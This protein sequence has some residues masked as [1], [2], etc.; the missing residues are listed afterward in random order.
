MQDRKSFADRLAN[1]K[2]SRQKL[3][4]RLKRLADKPKK[5][6]SRERKEST[7]AASHIDA[8]PTTRPEP[9]SPWK[10]ARIK[11]GASGAFKE[12]ASDTPLQ[13]QPWA[14]TLA[15]IALEAGE[16][17]R[18]HLCFVW[19]A[20]FEPVALL[21]S[22]INIERHFAKD[23]LGM[24][25]LLYPGTHATRLPLNST[26]VSRK[27]LVDLYRSMLSTEGGYAHFKAATTSKAFESVLEALNTIEMWG[28]DALDPA[29]GA[30]TP[31]F[32]FDHGK[33]VWESESKAQ[34]EK[35]LRK[36]AKRSNRRDIKEQLSSEWSDAR[37]APGALFV[38]HSETSRKDWKEALAASVLSEFHRPELLI[39]NGT[40]RASQ[41]SFGAVQ[42][43]PEFLKYALE[44]GYRSCGAI[45]I[46]DD[47]KSFFSLRARLA[48]LRITFTTNVFAAEGE[49]AI[50]ATEALPDTWQPAQRTLAYCSASIVDR[51]ASQAALAFQRI[52]NESGSE[53]DASHA[54]A[55][56]ACLFVLRLSNLPAG[57]SDLST[58]DDTE[59]D[60]RRGENS[61]VQ[62][63]SSLQSALATGAFNRKRDELERA[64]AKAEKL[65]DDWSDATPMAVRLLSEVRKY[66][67][68]SRSGLSIVLSSVHYVELA[69]RFL[70]RKIGAEWEQADQRTNW[71][72]QSAVKTALAKRAQTSHFVFVG[73]N[74]T[75]LKLLVTHQDIPHGSTILVAYRQA[76]GALMTLRGLR[77]VAEFKAYRGRIG[78]L[79]Q[80][81]ERRLAEVPNPLLIGKLG[82]IN[83]T[84]GFDELGGATSGGEQSLYKFDLENGHRMYA[85]GWIYRYGAEESPHFRRV[86]A[87]AVTVG[88]LVFEIG[89]ELK[90]ELENE[91]HV[92]SAD[93]ISALYPERILLKLY[94]DEVQSRCTRIYGAK[95]R[96]LLARSI[97]EAMIR[98]DPKVRDCRPGR[99]Y[100]W[101]AL[102][103]EGDTRPHAPKDAKY[104]KVFCKALEIDDE[105]A[106]RHWN[107]IRNARRLN[108][109]LGRELATR[110]AEILFQPESAEVYR[111]LSEATIKK[112]Q[113]RAVRCVF[114]VQGVMAPESSRAI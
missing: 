103:S 34:L 75:I 105:Q 17:G 53:G 91:L 66:A 83:L 61:W 20:E 21:H 97:L 71:I 26:S 50:L 112:L 27:G 1:Q 52:A 93:S 96:S 110:Y 73:I 88:D 94:H 41:S 109:N 19:P 82:D 60:Y 35:E 7:P 113:E 14:R 43:I 36:I 28:S 74:R 23:I 64:V 114:R 15:N 104:F 57:F 59:T 51:D 76:D 58:L 39:L 24:R 42:R 85:S 4:E 13:I 62:V 5:A 38:L 108:Q 22:I 45:V 86:A 33:G 29:L 89:E 8:P 55:M 70:K 31:V 32:V 37:E 95:K 46:T 47:P 16:S 100:Y 2:Q 92:G 25:T 79:I 10:R 80:E 111:K 56:A 63:K 99:I 101:L 102:G 87:S 84:F 67:I 98:I 9:V 78:L 69:R 49:Q 48:E 107:F 44:N 30:L 18:V 72:T 54:A 65:I 77:E 106:T 90:S 12:I 68:E 6:V 3:E 40:G 11:A 81:L